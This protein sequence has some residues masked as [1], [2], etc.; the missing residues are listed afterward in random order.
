MTVGQLSGDLNDDGKADAADAAL[1]MQYLLTKAAL[2]EEQ[3]SAADS[4]G[5]GMLTAADLT[6]L[7][8]SV[9]AE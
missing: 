9:L 8:A 2:T 6:L 1:L 3:A 4:D 7:K 5:D